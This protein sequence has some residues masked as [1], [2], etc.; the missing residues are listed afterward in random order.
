MAVSEQTLDLVEKWRQRLVPEWRIA[1]VDE[2]DGENMDGLLGRCEIEDPQYQRATIYLDPGST[3]DPE[4][5]A[6]IVHE[7]LHVL[8][9][10][11]CS[12]LQRLAS[13]SG[14]GSVSAELRLKRDNEERI[15]ERLA[16][17]L[18][19]DPPYGTIAA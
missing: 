17:A 19:Q 4:F 9:D 14:A 2:V 12:H 18:V 5:E 7:V 16:W 8:L 3:D 1:V 11:L 10:P 6:T 13:E 15:V